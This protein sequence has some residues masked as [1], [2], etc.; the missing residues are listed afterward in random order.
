MSTHYYYPVSRLSQPKEIISDVCIYGATSIGIVAAV[1][2]A[3][4]GKKAVVVE[5][6]SHIGGMST[7]GLGATDIGSKH[8]VGGMAR[9]FYKEIGSHYGMEERWRFEPHVASRVFNDWIERYNIPIFI[10]HR[11][12]RVEKA[13]QRITAL[14]M[15][16]GAVFRAAVF[17]DASYEGDLMARAG[18]SYTVGREGNH[19]YGEHFN[20]IHYGGPNHNF[21]RY[22][23]PYV[24]EGEPSS[25]L[26]PGMGHLPP[27]LHGDGDAL[28]QA[29]NFRLCLTHD[30]GNKIDFPKPA[31]YDP[32]RYELLRR[33]VDS[34][35]FDIFNLVIPLPNTKFDHNNWG[36]FNSDNIGAN[37]GWPDG[38]YELRE[39]IY[40]D[41]LNYQQG[42]FWFLANDPGLPDIVRRITSSWG[43]AADEFPDYGGWPPQLYIRE[44]RRMISDYVVTEN[45]AFCRCS[46]D[47]PVGMASYNIDSHNCKR[48]VIAG[49]AVNEGNVEVTPLAPF[50]VPYRAIRPRRQECTNLLVPVCI[51]ASHTAYGS[52][53]ME[54]VLMM[55]GQSAALAAAL[56]I[57]EAEGVVQNISYSSLERK[58]RDEGQ[59]LKEPRVS[60]E[61]LE[62]KGKHFITE[63]VPF[64]SSLTRLV[65]K[66][67]ESTREDHDE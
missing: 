8:V 36:G 27:G 65:R 57:D 9:N 23:D 42:L 13:G 17:I 14:H 10:K 38:D 24:K 51:S 50:P 47:D 60:A 31:E 30:A 18:V 62:I 21:T 26:L 16:N 49:R 5:F 7:S 29:Y 58:L 64:P 41:H 34:G 1:Q 59:V 32:L 20:G 52:I 48:T 66:G 22:V 44:A 2:S 43:L 63:P 37:Y 12:Q 11:L 33:Y 46:V 6:G 45:D 19:V 28:I 35:V 56:A 4:S 25:G 54:P 67:W 53:R 39:R 61:E 3:G 55:L 15:E 40:Q